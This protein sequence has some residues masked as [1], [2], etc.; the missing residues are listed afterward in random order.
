[1]NQITRR[2]FIKTLCN[3]LLLACFPGGGRAGPGIDIAELKAGYA[4]RLKSIMAHGTLPY[5]DTESSCNSSKVDIESIAQHIQRLNIGLMALSADIGKGRFAKGVRFDRLSERLISRYPDRFLP[6]GN[7][8]RP[9]FLTERSEAFFDA[10]NA[11]ALDRRIVLFG[12]YEF[13]HYPSPRQDRRGELGRDVKIPIDGPVGH[14]LFRMSEKTNLP[15]QIH[16]EVENELLAP[17]E[18]MLARYPGARVIW[19]HLAQVRYI[20]RATLYTPAYLDRLIRRFPNLYF[21]TAFGDAT[22]VY[23]P[24]GQRHARVWAASGGLKSEWRDLIVA[25]S[26]RFLSALDLGQDRLDK[27]GEHDKRHRNF[28]KQL[29]E[30]TRHQ[31]AYR[32][33]WRLLFGEEFA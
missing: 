15:F 26:S 29:P 18:S 13:R 27:I 25:H 21:D 4:Q 5:I 32:T 30:D 19:C 28:L 33:A 17:L 20:E 1:M 8:G 14:R 22:S 2:R 6:V 11:A 7:G 10:Q 24:S 3:V 9:P 16:Y 12:E 31:V 23:P